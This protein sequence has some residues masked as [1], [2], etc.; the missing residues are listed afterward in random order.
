MELVRMARIEFENFA[1][2]T[3]TGWADIT[4]TV[5][6]DNPPRT[7][8]LKDGVGALQFS[9][10]IYR[11]GPVPSPLLA[12]LRQMVEEFGRKRGLGEPS[13]VVV[14]AG[15]PITAAASFSCGK[16]FVRVWQ[17]SDGQNFALVTYTCAAQDRGS[18]L[19]VC[20]GVVRSI[21]FRSS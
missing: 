9:I 10:A 11:D 20:E 2:E 13:N 8:A 17:I 1:V 3:P 18:E 7:L 6:G 21:V 4:S 16:Y 15:P 12:D 5:A 19:L 14:E